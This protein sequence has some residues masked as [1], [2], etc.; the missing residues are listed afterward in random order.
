MRLDAAF[1]FPRL[2][3]G[4]LRKWQVG[5]SARTPDVVMSV[6]HLS[7]A[8]FTDCRRKATGAL[9][10]L[11]RRL[12]CILFDITVKPVYQLYKGRLFRQVVAGAVLRHVGFVLDGNRRYGLQW[13]LP[14]NQ[15]IY[16]AGAQK[17][18]EVLDWC[19][20]FGI[21]AVTPW[22]CSTENLSRPSD[23]VSAILGAIETKLRSLAR[24]P[25]LDDGRVRVEAIRRLELLPKQT[26]A[27]IRA[28]CDAPS[29]YNG[30]ALTNAV[31]Y[32]GCQ[33]I[34][35]AVH[36]F[37]DG[38]EVQG[39]TLRYAVARITPD[40]IKVQRYL[41][42]APDPD[43]PIRT[44]DEIRLSGFLRRQS[45]HSEIYFSGV[46]WPAFRKIDR[47]HAIRAFRPRGRRFGL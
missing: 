1:D 7:I 17:L 41:P 43:L 9:Q 16:V 46:F 19:D 31:A 20:A 39:A 30:M 25:R 5:K 8:L 4:Y 40:A 23:K 3:H 38:E 26:R 27:A 42:D 11:S 14:D 21:S 37:R 24:D 18:D 15:Q 10:W 2:S 35:N 6:Q 36:M 33:E 28:T 47:L 34:V 44:R 32:G 45:A 12:Q 22:V 29:D 13:G